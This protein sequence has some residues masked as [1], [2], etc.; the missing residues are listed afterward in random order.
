MTITPVNGAVEAI[1]TAVYL[2]VCMSIPAYAFLRLFKVMVKWFQHD[3]H[4][5][6]YGIMR[7]PP[8]RW[9]GYTENYTRKS[10]SPPRT[11][12]L[13]YDYPAMI[14]LMGHVGLWTGRVCYAISVAAFVFSILCIWFL[15]FTS[16][17][18]V[19]LG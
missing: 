16:S 17:K 5:L 14:R 12:T 13:T 1:N 2:M 3:T 10:D 18:S 7:I 8:V 4:R 9:N 19:L 6:G 15:L 11:R